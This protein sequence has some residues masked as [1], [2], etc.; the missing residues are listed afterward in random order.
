LI[1]KPFQ[2]LVR[3]GLDNFAPIVMLFLY[4]LL[5]VRRI[6]ARATWRTDQRSRKQECGDTVS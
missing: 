3:R 6:E 1:I 4:R 2:Y 5:L